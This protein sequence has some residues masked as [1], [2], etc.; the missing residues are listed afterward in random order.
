MV[1]AQ[2]NNRNNLRTSDMRSAHVKLGL[3]FLTMYSNFGIGDKL[4]K[5]GNDAEKL[6]KALAMYKD[7]T[8]GLKLRPS[9]ASANKEL[10]RQNDILL[11]DRLDRYYMS[12]AQ[13]I[14]AITTPGI[15]P[16]LMSYYCDQLLA[17]R[18]VQQTLLRNFNKDNPDTILPDVSKIIETALRS[19]Q[20]AG[21]GNGNNQDSRLNP[22]SQV[23]SGAMGAGGVPAGT[24][25][26]QQDAA[27]GV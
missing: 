7:G 11:S 20:G 1:M 24:G 19:I 4:R 3:K 8:L 13:M 9:S 25:L 22:T 15:N 10:E 26:S 14:Q 5:Y 6:K 27:G 23:P 12:Q 21:A 18:A 17:T 16:E 2:Q